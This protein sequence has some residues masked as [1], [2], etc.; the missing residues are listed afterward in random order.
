MSQENVEIVR[1]EVRRVQRQGAGR[2]ETLR[3]LLRP[4]RRAGATPTAPIDGAAYPGREARQRVLGGLARELRRRAGSSSIEF[5]DRGAIRSSSLRSA[6]EGRG[7]RRAAS[8]VDTT[9][10][11]L[12]T[13]RDGKVV[14]RSRLLRPRRKPS[15]PPG[16]GSSEILRGRCRRRTWRSCGK[17]SGRDL[18]PRRDGPAIQ[19]HALR[20]PQV[21]DR[22]VA[23]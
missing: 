20:A 18:G 15:K 10:A 22:D 16:C 13:F 14:S 8:S 23:P 12:W 4:R 9:I 3:R 1:D 5:I 11:R 6:A 17:P 2:D 19:V 7:A 21:S